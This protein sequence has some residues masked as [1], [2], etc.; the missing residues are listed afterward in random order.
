M[1]CWSDESL[2]GIVPHWMCS[3][4]SVLMVQ[5]IRVYLEHLIQSIS[6]VSVCVKASAGI[7][8]VPSP[9]PRVCVCV[10]VCVCC[11]G[12]AREWRWRGEQGEDPELWPSFFSLTL[13]LSSEKPEMT[14]EKAMSCEQHWS[15]TKVW[16]LSLFPAVCGSFTAELW[17]GEESLPLVSR[18]Q[19]QLTLPQTR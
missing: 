2:N 3:D 19:E 6:S 18:L 16:I 5:C 4:L 15:W 11:M 10:C 14:N 9:I 1:S 12:T 17:R 7:V 8:A 13:E